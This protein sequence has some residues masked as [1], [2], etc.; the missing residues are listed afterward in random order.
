MARSGPGGWLYA[1]IQLPAGSILTSI[2]WDVEDYCNVC[3][4]QVAIEAFHS[5]GSRQFI[6]LTET[7][8]TDRPGR[9]VIVDAGVAGHVVADGADY[10]LQALASNWGDH[11]TGFVGVYSATVE[12]QVA[13]PR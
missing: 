10:V 4:L 1:P 9:H 12:Y 13:G 5:D 7:G 3:A 11:T 2:T 8:L 6:G